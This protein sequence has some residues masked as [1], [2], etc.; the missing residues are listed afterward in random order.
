[1]SPRDEVGFLDKLLVLHRK[2]TE[3]WKRLLY[4]IAI[5]G[6][7]FLLILDVL[8]GW[9]WYGGEF[10]ETT[11]SRTGKII[12]RYN[13]EHYPDK[14]GPNGATIIHWAK[15]IVPIEEWPLPSRLTYRKAQLVRKL[16]RHWDD[17]HAV[18]AISLMEGW[19]SERN[20]TPWL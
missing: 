9:L 17:E 11:S 5:W 13:F 15:D 2:E 20:G 19:G 14:V 3:S 1:M 8:F 6:F 10:R 18:E 16:T 12:L 7:Q 4:A